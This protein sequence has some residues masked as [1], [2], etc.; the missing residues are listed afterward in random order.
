[1]AGF[2]RD[3]NFTKEPEFMKQTKHE[4][5]KSFQKWAMPEQRTQ[6]EASEM[7]DL[8]RVKAFAQ[9]RKTHIPNIGKNNGR[10]KHAHAQPAGNPPAFVAMVK[11]RDGLLP[12]NVGRSNGGARVSSKGQVISAQ[13]YSDYLNRF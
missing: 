4:Q 11:S 13:V 2:V 10:I 6:T 9:G 12:R 3:L 1:M 7:L 8:R 5:R